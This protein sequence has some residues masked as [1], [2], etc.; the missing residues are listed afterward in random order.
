MPTVRVE[1]YRN[2]AKDCWSVRHRGIVIHRCQTITLEN[3][4]FSVSEA[5]RQRVLRERR[6]NVH[7][8]VRGTIVGFEPLSNGVEVSYNPYLGP[9]FFR[10]S[11]GVGV[12]TARK[13]HM[14]YGRVWILE[15]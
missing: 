8:V 1:V 4:V 12:H 6:K 11:D 3:V 14:D 7:A 2:L 9:S 5:G 13:V 10:V 15:D